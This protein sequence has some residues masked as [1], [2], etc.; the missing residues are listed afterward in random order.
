M[1]SYNTVKTAAQSEFEE[2]RSRFIGY[3]K[4]VCSE[5]EAVSFIE[6]IKALHREAT[7]NV[8]AYSLRENQMTRY[9][10]DGEPHG[11][12]GLPALSVLTGKKITDVAVV[13]TRYFGGTLLGKGGLVRAYA[14]AAKEAVEAAEIITMGFCDVLS[15]K[16]DYSLYEPILKVLDSSGAFIKETNFTDCAEI[17]FSVLNEK[18]QGISEKIIE[19][20]AGKS[21]P[22]LISQTFS[23]I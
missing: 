8:Y 12:A 9:S 5:V 11:T 1:N 7:H 6:E 18:T 19:M 15:V 16:S 21:N 22:V 3:A 17:I 23:Q 13:V 2:S 4:P 20:T 14:R 10:D